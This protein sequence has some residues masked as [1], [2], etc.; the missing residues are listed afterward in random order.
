M[1]SPTYLF[2][3]DED[4]TM[5]Q[6]PPYYEETE[7]T[8]GSMGVSATYNINKWFRPVKPTFKLK[9]HNNVID[10]KLDDAIGHLSSQFQR[11]SE[12]CSLRS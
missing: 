7:F 2:Y 12:S 8:N 3:C 4:L 9:K 1:G 6:L 11:S 10:I 5:S